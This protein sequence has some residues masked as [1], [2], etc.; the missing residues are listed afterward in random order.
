[1]VPYSSNARPNP[2]GWFRL[3]CSDN[4]GGCTGKKVK[5]RAITHSGAQVPK[6]KTTCPRSNHGRR[7]KERGPTLWSAPRQPRTLPQATVGIDL[8][9]RSC[10]G[11]TVTVPAASVH[12]E[13]IQG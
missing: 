2:N 10:A 13:P 6:H 4:T 9:W 11:R 3:V 8:P 1:M 12:P 7:P 5:T